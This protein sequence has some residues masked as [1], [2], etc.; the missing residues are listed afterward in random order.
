MMQSL[1]GQ[2]EFVEGKN[3]NRGG[4]YIQHGMFGGLDQDPEV[5]GDQGLLTYDRMYVV[6]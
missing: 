6:R 4:R 3:A 2:P 5:V 1:R